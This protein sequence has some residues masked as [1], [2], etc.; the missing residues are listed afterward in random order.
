MGKKKNQNKSE[1]PVV[2]VVP[3]V[4][5]GVDINL[6][7]CERLD[8]MTQSEKVD[9]ILD[10][11]ITGKVVVL[12]RGLTPQEEAKLIEATMMRIDADTFIGIEM[13]SYGLETQRSIIQKWLGTPPRPRMAVIGP[14]N[15]L[16]MVRKDSNQ[17]QARIL[18][19]Q[20]IAAVA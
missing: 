14:A 18:S 5:A 16:S 4:E 13:Q 10:E 11:I 2:P 7:S 12:E 6:V 1:T 20:G 17:I 15:R 3:D 9:Y 8:D 19:S